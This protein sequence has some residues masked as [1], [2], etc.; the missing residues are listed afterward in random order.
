MTGINTNI[1]INRDYYFIY[2]LLGNPALPRLLKVTPALN[3]LP[4]NFFALKVDLL[5]PS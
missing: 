1:Q 3:D 2:K 4:G 5:K